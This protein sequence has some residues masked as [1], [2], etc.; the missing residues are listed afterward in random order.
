MSFKNFLNDG[1]TESEFLTKFGKGKNLKPFKKEIETGLISY[2]LY[3]AST[4]EAKQ[5]MGDVK[6]ADFKSGEIDEFL[7]RSAIYAVRILRRLNVDII[8][9]PVSSSDLTKE[10]VKRIAKR[11]HYDVYIDSFKKQ[12]D[13]SKIEIDREHPKITNAIIKSMESIIKNAIK[14]GNLSV[15][16]FSPMHRKFIKNMFD[17]TDPKLLSKF[18][19]KNVVI[20][21]DIM[22]SGTSAKNIYNVLVTNGATSVDALTIFKSA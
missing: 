18:D 6:A 16:M 17:I 1:S 2:S 12:P 20:I 11:T 4:K 14:K 21:D 7:T 13:I 22:T 9:T 19:G 10:F 15:R 5:V 3:N 8:V